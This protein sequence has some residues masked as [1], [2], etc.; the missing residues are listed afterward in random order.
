MQYGKKGGT[1]KRKNQKKKMTLKGNQKKISA[2]EA[3]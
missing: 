1:Q 2:G 3:L